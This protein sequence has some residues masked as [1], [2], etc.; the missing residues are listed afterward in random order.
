MF[1]VLKGKLFFFDLVITADKNMVRK[2]IKN[3]LLL[4]VNTGV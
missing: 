3:L 1:P 2:K 4:T